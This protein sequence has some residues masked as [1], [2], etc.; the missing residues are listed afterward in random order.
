MERN[1]I[2]QRQDP[3]VPG[4]KTHSVGGTRFCECCG[5]RLSANAKFCPG[6]GTQVQQQPQG[7]TTVSRPAPS[8]EQQMVEQYKMNIKRIGDMLRYRNDIERGY[9]PDGR[10]QI[11]MA[12]NII[13]SQMDRLT[14]DIS[15][16]P[17]N[18]EIRVVN[19]AANMLL[20]KVMYGPISN[21][22]RD[23]S[24]E[25]GVLI[26]N[27]SRQTIQSS[28]MEMK[29]QVIDRILR[30]EKTMDD[31]ILVL[32]SLLDRAKDSLRYTPASFEL[33]RHYLRS[34]EDEE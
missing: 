5:N 25:M 23:L 17:V 19:R 20:Q 27:W 32:R 11:E 30:G 34:L 16:T 28:E 9:G 33:S 12:F 22:V 2:G 21:I 29:T 24:V 13:K 8:A 15:V 26:F 18:D 1:Q 3:Q 10:N 31:T 14:Q 7:T 6:C 4:P